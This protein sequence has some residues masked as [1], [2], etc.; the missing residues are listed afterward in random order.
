MI[1]KKILND[2]EGGDAK[3]QVK[4]GSVYMLNYDFEKASYW[5]YKAAQ[6]DDAKFLQ[7]YTGILKAAVDV[8]EDAGF[9]EPPLKGVFEEILKSI[10]SLGVDTMAADPAYSRI[11]N[12]VRIILG[13]GRDKA[14]YNIVKIKNDIKE[15]CGNR[16]ISNDDKITQLKGKLAD[17]VAIL[18]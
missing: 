5:F 12:Y 1:D 11:N 14:N 16:D 8:F 10:G 17:I 3:A 2:A 4:V 15:L 7:I 6:Q 18:S 9:P 13:E